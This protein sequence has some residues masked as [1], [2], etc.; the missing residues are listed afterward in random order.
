MGR[1]VNNVCEGVGS[2]YEQA[3][4]AVLVGTADVAMGVN[5]C[6]RTCGA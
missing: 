2:A 4:Q 3:I 1:G 6:G 5:E